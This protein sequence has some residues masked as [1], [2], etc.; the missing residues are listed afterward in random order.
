MIAPTGIVTSA[1]AGGVTRLLDPTPLSPVA[2]G[3]DLVTDESCLM[4]AVT[5][6]KWFPR[7]PHEAARPRVVFFPSL[8]FGSW[9]RHKRRAFA[10]QTQSRTTS[11]LLVAGL[12]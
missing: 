9:L 7:D 1:H 6:S 4:Q 8:D 12:P 2:T 10:S 5:Q 3:V 11:F